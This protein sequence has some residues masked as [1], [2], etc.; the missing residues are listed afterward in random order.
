MSVLSVR[1]RSIAVVEL[2]LAAVLV[3][4]IDV[5][6]AGLYWHLPPSRIFQSIAAWVIGRDAFAAGAYS[7]VLGMAVQY[8]L[9]TA[10][11][12]GYRVVVSFVPALRRHPVP[13]GVL[14]GERHLPKYSCTLA[15]SLQ[16]ASRSVINPLT[17]KNGLSGWPPSRLGDQN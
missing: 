9:M 11:I 8:G 4:N 13:G 17:Y 16:G 7:I 5:A 1:Q 6:V 3:G 14:N 12:A 15:F 2:L 10:A